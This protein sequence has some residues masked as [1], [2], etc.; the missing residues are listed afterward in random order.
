M[1]FALVG[2]IIEIISQM[3]IFKNNHKEETKKDKS[4]ELVFS[5]KSVSGTVIY[6]FRFLV[7][8]LPGD[9]FCLLLNASPFI[10]NSTDQIFL[11][12]SEVYFY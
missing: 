10:L 6:C 1:K 7:N 2:N 9:A 8:T 11:W 3:L 5:D 4:V 12:I